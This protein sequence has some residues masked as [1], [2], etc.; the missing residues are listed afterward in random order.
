MGG[1]GLFVRDAFEIGL[2]KDT[3]VGTADTDVN[4][5]WGT[6]SVTYCFL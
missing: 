3:I 6:L 1:R 5:F 2:D 4:N